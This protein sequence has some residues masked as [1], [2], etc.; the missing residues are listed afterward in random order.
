MLSRLIDIFL[1]GSM[2]PF[3]MI[4]SLVLGIGAIALTPREEEPQ[5]VVPMADVFIRAPGLSV[6]AVERQIVTPL[7]KLLNQI[8]GVEH[9]YS[10]S[11]AGRAVVTVRFFVGEDREDSLVKIYNKLYSNTDIVPPDVT[12]WVVKPIEID[13]VP[14]VNVSLWSD[15]P[16]AVGDFELRRIAEELEIELKALHDTNKTS[17][18]GGR[19]RV[20][21]VELDPA[22]LA[23]RQTSALDVAW[24]LRVSNVQQVAGSFDRA[25][26]S[27]PV[28]VGGFF[29]SAED[30]TRAVVNVVDGNPVLL[31][32]VAQVIDGPGERTS[33][34]SIGFGPA[35]DG[36]TRLEQGTYYPV[37]HVAVAKQ[38]GTNAVE[39]A[40]RVIE[41]VDELAPVLFPE[42]VQARITRNYGETAND[43]VNELLEALL[44]AV[45]IVIAL[46]A[47]SLGW[48][49]GLIVATAVPI[50][51]AL[52]LTVNYWAGYTINRVTLFALILSLG[53]VVDDPVVDVE[54]I[55]RHLKMGRE[56]ALDAVRTAVNEVRP[57]ILLATLAVIVSFLPMYLITGMMGPY[58]SP[59]AL[60]V[61]VAMLMSMV[62]AFTITPWIS[63]HVLARKAGGGDETAVAPIQ[64]SMLYRAYAGVLG[65]L[66]RR[67]A[68]AWSFGG[69]LVILFG[70]A[71]ML[72]ALRDVPLKLLP[73]DNKNE[74][75]IVINPPEG[76]T[77]ERTDA[78]ARDLAEVLRRAPEV[79]DFQIY[80]GLASPMDFNGMVRHYALREGP[81][82]A[83]IRVNLVDKGER[84]MQSHEIA[85]RLRDELE[86]V[87][88]AAGARIAIVEVPP[89]PPVLATITA[90]VYGEPDLPYE[91]IRGAARALEARLI[92]EPGVSDVDSTV[93]DDS[94]RLVFVTDKEKAALSGVATDDIVQT[95]TL[96]L[97]GLDVARL[98]QP[99]EVSP[100]PIRLQLDR[101]ERSG[102]EALDG[103]AV[104]GRPG[105]VKTRT[106]GG[107]AEAPVPVVRLGELGTFERRPAEKAIYHKNL[108]RVAYVYAEPVG[109]APADVVAD[110]AADR[111][112][113]AKPGDQGNPRPVSDRSFLD[114]GGGLAWAL[115]E[116]ISV[117]WFGEGELNIT[118]DVFRD[119]G[120]AFGVALIGIYL[121]LVYQ[122]ASYAMPLILMISIPLTMI[123]IMPGFWVLNLL[124][125]APIAGYGNPVFFTAT[126]MIGMIALSGIAVRNAILLIEFLHVGLA[127]G[128]TLRDALFE[129][130]A[131][132]MRPIL[133]TAGPSV[134]A[135]I[136]ITLDPVFS[137]L[138]WALIFG[139]FVSTAFT[140]LVVPMTYFWVYR[141]RPGHGLPARMKEAS[142]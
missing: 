18:Y 123:G 118:R 140:L 85:L 13:D 132:R 128:Q 34:T 130:G 39:V 101:A 106:S 95:V 69:L 52:T 135:A 131:V 50:T 89:G 35:D 15:R 120:I 26:R 114:N 82:V 25:E 112:V 107:I 53:M 63:Y 96:A 109:R 44:V 24:A 48:R 54:N 66:V 90:E 105:V 124:T 56:S 27:F 111:V 137:G 38:K 43:K 36:A 81:N 16:E 49:E 30:L 121:I 58:M 98:Q 99:R 78:I 73:F 4:V 77:L 10:A 136:P 142:Q 125:G 5:I 6:E 83:E 45:I 80:S 61:P 9:V 88:H 108:R 60:N 129:A 117:A 70:V 2:A 46:L 116:G 20:I 55:H 42:G 92:A 68:Y 62:V 76:T 22:R 64:Q 57:P 32:D 12:S 65:P 71:A 40:D 126:A 115:P 141:N 127:R 72:M 133:L 100:L 8:D 37:V 7:E 51:F 86:A 31:G 67:P 79:R 1:R 139:L 84:E 11:Y 21:R 3:I 14:I 17:I 33:Y 110:I 138:A 74:F 87:A 28:E 102:T 134:L 94:T 122:T 113:Q 103:M 41:R 19:P 97:S 91:R 75:Q 104:K 47:Y 119:L 59:M 23:A 29:D 93:E